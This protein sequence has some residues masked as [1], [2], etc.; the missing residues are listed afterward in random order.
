MASIAINV[1][2]GQWTISGTAA[3][4]LDRHAVPVIPGDRVGMN[5]VVDLPDGLFAADQ[6]R[7][8]LAGV[9]GGQELEQLVAIAGR[10][11]RLALS[12]AVDPALVV[13]DLAMQRD[14]RP[15]GVTRL[16]DRHRQPLG[17]VA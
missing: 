5:H 16:D 14:A 3:Q 6:Q 9:A 10:E 13:V 12:Q 8:E 11:H 17:G 15:V 2:V 7:E 4:R 1:S